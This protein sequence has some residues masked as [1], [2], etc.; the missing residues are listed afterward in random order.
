MYLEHLKPE[1]NELALPNE[2]ISLIYVTTI[3]AIYLCQKM[4]TQK[5]NIS[6]TD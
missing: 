4:E 3:D 1:Q 2:A 6:L 5:E